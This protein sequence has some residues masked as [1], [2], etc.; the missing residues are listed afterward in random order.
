MKTTEL[1]GALL[2][3]WV[4]MAEGLNQPRLVPRAAGSAESLVCMVDDRV[5]FQPS[6][7]LEQG[8][9]I[10]ARHRGQDEISR[11]AFGAGFCFDL[12]DPCVDELIQ[13]LPIDLPA[14]MRACV[15]KVFGASVPDS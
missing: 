13:T 7:N 11:A 5:D 2:D 8:G 14:T 12:S 6:T 9:A 4:A 3:Y 15:G 10:F 1:S